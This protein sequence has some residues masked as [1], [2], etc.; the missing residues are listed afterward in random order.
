MLAPYRTEEE[1][2][3]DFQHAPHPR[4]EERKA[5]QPP[6][7]ADQ[8]GES[9]NA[10]IGLRVTMIVGTM[11]AAYIFTTLA[12][13]SLPSVIKTGSAVLIV[14]WIAQTFLQLVLLPIII[15]GQ[16]VQSKAAD[17]RAEMTYKDA[18]AVLHEAREIQRHLK[19]QDEALDRIVAHL[20]GGASPGAA[21]A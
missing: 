12:L 14:A 6:K 10:R 16:N 4:L 11:W 19:A 9:L 1:Q 15:V 21:S 2:V 18:E 17:K 3:V 7:V 13:V 8:L 5:E 20:G